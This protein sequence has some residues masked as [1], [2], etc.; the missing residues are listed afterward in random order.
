MGQATSN[1]RSSHRTPPRRRKGARGTLV[2]IG[3]A[4][5]VCFA[6]GF[7]LLWSL[8][9][10][11]VGGN[12]FPWTATARRRDLAGR[13]AGPGRS[14]AGT[15]GRPA[16]LPGP[17][18][19]PV[20]GIYVTS[21]AAG[22]PATSGE[23][24]RDM[25]IRPRSMRLSSMSKMSRG[26]LV[27]NAD[28]PLAKSLGLSPSH[29]PD[30]DG[31]ISHPARAQHHAHRPASTF[32]TA[33][34]PRPGPIWLYRAPR[35][36][37]GEDYKGTGYTN[38]YNHEVWEYEVQVAEDAARHGFREIQFDYVRFP[39]DGLVANEAVYPGGYSTKADAIAGFLGY[40]RDRLEKLG[41]WVSADVFGLTTTVKNDS[42]YRP[43]V[44]EDLLRTS[45]S[46]ARWS[47]PRTTMPGR[48]ASTRPTP[49]P[50]S[51]SPPP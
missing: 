46:S 10:V 37:C 2:F 23:D 3:L 15:S 42:G 35:A 5:A 30:V 28:V 25:P 34:W 40:A 36:G 20:K 43:A 7:I 19:V 49:R 16:G 44:R 11:I 50:T 21:Y 27:Y 6:A 17:L 45:T 31:L 8:G 41:V 22:K 12:G 9:S 26:R 38:P 13:A 32:R 39:S 29:I 4:T 24:D 14:P 51:W 48:T 47:I 18:Y 33:P 1:G